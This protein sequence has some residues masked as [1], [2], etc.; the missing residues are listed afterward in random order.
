MDFV[1]KAAARGRPPP[2][3]RLGR[4]V[5]IVLAGAPLALCGVPRAGAEQRADTMQAQWLVGLAH[6]RD[7]AERAVSEPPSAAPG[8]GPA[9]PDPLPAHAAAARALAAGDALGALAALS[10]A[11]V[12]ERGAAG[13]EREA[14]AGRALSQL[15]R[16]AEADAA[17]ARAQALDPRGEHLPAWV[18]PTE[19][20][21]NALAWADRTPDPAERRPILER[22]LAQVARA[23]RDRRRP[24]RPVL[25]LLRVELLH[26][27]FEAAAPKDRRR[28]A[29]RLERAARKFLERYPNAPRAPEVA[30]LGAEATVVARGEKAG[31][32]AMRAVAARYAGTPA[33]AEAARRLSSLGAGWAPSRTERLQQAA[34][35][36]RLRWYDASRA[37]L[38]ALLAE[39]DLPPGFRRSVLRERAYTAW[40]QRDYAR[41]AADLRE[42]Y[43][44]TVVV[45][46]DLVRC[47]ERARQYDEALGVILGRARAKRG[48]RR[49]GFVW[50]AVSLAFRGGMYERTLAL[51]DDYEALSKG[52]PLDRAFYRGMA[53]LRLGRADEALPHLERFERGGGG[54]DRARARYLRARAQIES[55]D[56]ETRRAGY[57]T[58]RRIAAASPLRYYGLWAR[59]HLR[60]ANRPAPDLPEAT[61]PARYREH[62]DFE[63]T[64]AVLDGLAAR[65]GEALPPLARARAL[66]GAGYVEEARREV[67]RAVRTVRALRARRAGRRP[68]RAK[69]EAL[70]DGLSWEA[71]FRLPRL[72]SSRALR[73]LLRDDEA[74]RALVD[75]L[76]RASLGLDEPYEALRLGPADG[77]TYGLR[78]MVRAYAPAVEA[79]AGRWGFDPSHLWALMYTESRFRRFVVSPVGAR[80][81]VQIMPYTARRLA[82]RLGEIPVGGFFDPDHLY[83][84]DTNT[85]LAAYYLAELA[86]KF[87]GQMPLAYAAYNG[88]PTS[89]ARWV[90]A[91]TSRPAPLDLFIEEIPFRETR[92]YVRRVMETQARYVFLATGDVPIWH[93]TV[94]PRV[95]RNIDF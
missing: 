17:L 93:G 33:A 50:S 21:K 91:K 53:L 31:A 12:P 95:R 24:N 77:D 8:P 62:P 74:G 7:R 58:L 43:A 60:V 63:E 90:T 14:L 5:R 41:C 51:L 2:L 55:A 65:Y 56:P 34:T 64:L 18:I 54:G 85:R 70:A 87:Q 75:G 68:W 44:R 10:A 3:R 48:R 11:S 30:W 32:E 79:A 89:V 38:D 52:H 71:S 69:S 76:V 46:G 28:A 9:A 23:G 1:R 92:R 84:I 39:P 42:L 25:D 61:A 36:R 78:W 26:R 83:D 15:G 72:A 27:A 22:G 6:P 94:D 35:A 19:R 47:L 16:F 80:G 37:L 81:A 4:A 49:A 13:V 82:E 88:G 59:S 73:K 20:A 40:R 86:V 66:L 29:R 67:R 57:E 45:Y